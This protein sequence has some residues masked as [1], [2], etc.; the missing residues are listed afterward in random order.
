LEASELLKN[1]YWN[2]YYKLENLKEEL[3]DIFMYS[4][5]LADQLND[6]LVEI[7]HEKNK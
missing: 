2:N 1:F 4:I 7:A 3:A 5:Q 6:D